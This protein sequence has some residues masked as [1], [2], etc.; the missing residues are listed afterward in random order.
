MRY[1]NLARRLAGGLLLRESKS[2]PNETVSTSITRSGKTWGDFS[3]IFYF[4]KSFDKMLTTTKAC[5]S[6]VRESDGFMFYACT[7]L[8]EIARCSDFVRVGMVL[9][10]AEF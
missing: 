4:A 10:V 7:G 8:L 5:F 3:R 1:S 9:R 6:V 2:R